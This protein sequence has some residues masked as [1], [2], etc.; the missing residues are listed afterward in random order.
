MCCTTTGTQ[1]SKDLNFQ[2]SGKF[3]SRWR[4][5]GKPIP[6]GINFSSFKRSQRATV[7]NCLIRVLD[8]FNAHNVGPQFQYVGDASKSAFFISFR[9]DHP[10]CYA[11][12]FFPSDHP[13]D[14]YIV[15]YRLGL[16][17]DKE[18]KRHLRDTAGEHDNIKDM[19]QKALEQNITQILAHELLH[20]VGVRHCDVNPQD[21]KEPYVRFPRGQS[22]EDNFDPLMR[23]KLPWR[24]FSQLDW[25]PE[26]LEEIRQL[27]AMKAGEKIGPYT[28]RDVSWED[29]AKRRKKIA[30][31]NARY[32]VPKRRKANRN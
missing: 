7:R 10:D 24:D 16:T 23:T 21:E 2:V 31:N 1:V 11:S 3:A 19:K 18:Q 30:I 29:G 8:S 9:G 25:K 22:D 15:V 13:K 17:L 12:S 26:T 6:V 32:S 5:T 28:I 4:L 27:Y 20:I 14:W